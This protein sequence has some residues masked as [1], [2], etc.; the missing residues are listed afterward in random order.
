MRYWRFVGTKAIKLGSCDKHPVPGIC[1]RNLSYINSAAHLQFSVC[2]EETV[3]TN[4]VI[5]ILKTRS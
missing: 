5:Y 3:I 4:H 2:R 1:E